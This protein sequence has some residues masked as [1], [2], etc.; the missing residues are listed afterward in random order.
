MNKSKVAIS[1]L[2]LVIIMAV[3]FYFVGPLREIVPKINGLGGFVEPRS[4][5]SG[6]LVTDLSV[7]PA[8]VQPN[9]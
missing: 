4:A 6:F 1:V 5:G 7:K 3:G 9:E 8:K 2:L